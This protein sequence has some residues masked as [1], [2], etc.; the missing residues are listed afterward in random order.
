MLHESF[1]HGNIRFSSGGC[2][3]PPAC[4]KIKNSSFVTVKYGGWVGR[5]L[6]FG[7]W[8]REDP[9]TSDFYS[10]DTGGFN[11]TVLLKIKT[12]Y[13][14]RSRGASVDHVVHHTTK[15]NSC[16]HE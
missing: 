16:V 3:T 11:Q 4:T 10:I 15:K 8:L 14:N 9:R 2:F 6:V 7:R 13:I 1:K 12:T 5:S